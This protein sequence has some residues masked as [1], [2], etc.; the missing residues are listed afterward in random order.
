MKTGQWRGVELPC[1]LLTGGADR[2]AD[3]E[4]YGSAARGSAFPGK[5]ICSQVRGV[6]PAACTVFAIPL[7]FPE[8]QRGEL[9]Q[10]RA[11]AVRRERELVVRRQAR[12]QAL[13]DYVQ[14][15]LKEI[16]V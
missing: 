16:E 11:A 3:T 6:G 13:K 14:R 5:I 8:S 2:V 4:N 15:R 9:Q 12:L 10:W 1:A 7:Q